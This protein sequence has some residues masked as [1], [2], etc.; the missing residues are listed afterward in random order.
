M[1]SPE[2]AN[3][4][5]PKVRFECKNWKNENPTFTPV[6]CFVVHSFI[7][8]CQAF[9]NWWASAPLRTLL[10]NFVT[11]TLCVECDNFCKVTNVIFHFLGAPPGLANKSVFYGDYL[12]VKFS[13]LVLQSLVLQ[14]VTWAAALESSP[15]SSLNCSL[16]LMYICLNITE[17]SIK[18]SKQASEEK[19]LPKGYFHVADICNMF[20]KWKNKFDYVFMFHVLNELP[21]LRKGM[22]RNHVRIK[23]NT[24]IPKPIS[25]KEKKLVVSSSNFNCQTDKKQWNEVQILPAG[26]KCYCCYFLSSVYEQ[27]PLSWMANPFKKLHQVHLKATTEE[28]VVP[29]MSNVLPGQKISETHRFCNSKKQAHSVR[30]F[31]SSVF[32]SKIAFILD[33]LQESSF[34]SVES[35]VGSGPL[36]SQASCWVLLHDLV[37]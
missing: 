4:F 18:F 26:V 12:K 7:C 16:S 30:D 21:S 6:G 36:S 27:Q 22:L 9:H 8:S 1:E 29:C 20:P 23:L 34:S 14:C 33:L 25:H 24:P 35:S 31:L 2:H 3:C 5:F 10:F 13:F 11:K 37:S 32:P 28:T 15:H 19:F 17:H